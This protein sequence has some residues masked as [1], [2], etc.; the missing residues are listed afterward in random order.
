MLIEIESQNDVCILRIKGRF[1][2]GT[3]PGYLRSQAD[4]VKAFNYHK[5]LVD[6]SQVDAIGSTFIGFVAAL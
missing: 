2:T 6:L 4:A 1:A 3:D 5:L